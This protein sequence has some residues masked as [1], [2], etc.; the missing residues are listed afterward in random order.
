[1]E[2]TRSTGLEPTNGWHC[3]PS[4]ESWLVV[5][6]Q[7][8]VRALLGHGVFGLADLTTLPS[9]QHLP[10]NGEAVVLLRNPSSDVLQLATP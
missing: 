2:R 7:K 5:V 4:R 3:E 8:R 6:I 1:M 9:D 10:P